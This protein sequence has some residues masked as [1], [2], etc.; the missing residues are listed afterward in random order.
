M[1]HSHSQTSWRP[2]A[3]FGLMALASLAHAQAPLPQP[4]SEGVLVLSA[5]ATQEVPRDWMSLTLSVSREGSDATAVQ[6]QLKQAVDAALAEARKQA[7]PGQV[8]LQ[9]GGFS[10]YPRYGSKGQLTGWQGSTELVVEGRDMATIGQLSGRISSMTIQR[11]NYSLSREAREKVEAEVAAQAIARF[12]ARAAEQARLFGYAA[13][14]V[15]EV[16]V[17]LDQPGPMPYAAPRVAMAMAKAPE[18]DALP[19]EA[20]KGTVSATVSGSV[21]MK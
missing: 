4:A 21:Q 18:G 1:N 15:R 5:S 3:A 11:V 17:A 8:E 2:V 19:V 20:G 10:I 9:T 6:N 14:A 13:Y 16:N 7:R 12:R